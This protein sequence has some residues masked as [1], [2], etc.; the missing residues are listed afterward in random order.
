MRRFL[1]WIWLRRRIPRALAEPKCYGAFCEKHAPAAL[2]N[3]CKQCCGGS[4]VFS[5]LF[6][7]WQ[8]GHVFDGSRSVTSGLR[9]P[10]TGIGEKNLASQDIQAALFLWRHHIPMQCQQRCH[11]GHQNADDRKGDRILAKAL[12]STG[13]NNEHF[14]PPSSVLCLQAWHEASCGRPST[15]LRSHQSRS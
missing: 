10:G 2:A 8:A 6:L 1:R 14:G 9:L 11:S 13:L 5:V 15:R 7:V 3:D 4:P 12:G